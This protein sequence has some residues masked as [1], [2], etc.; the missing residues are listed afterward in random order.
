MHGDALR[1]CLA[2]PPVDGEAN[3]ELEKLLAGQLGLPRSSVRVEKGTG[4]RRKQVRLQ[5][6]SAFPEA[7]LEARVSTD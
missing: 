6:L 5:G 1:V 4:S 3:A 2:A 7:W